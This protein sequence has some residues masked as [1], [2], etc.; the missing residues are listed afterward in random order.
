M[1][2]KTFNH[3]EKLLSYDIKDIVIEWESFC[4]HMGV[5]VKFHDSNSIING[6]FIGLNQKGDAKIELNG[7]EMVIN[8][9]IINL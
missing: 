1:L 3:F 2:A 5:F 9:G 8:S 4:N 6:E 7:E